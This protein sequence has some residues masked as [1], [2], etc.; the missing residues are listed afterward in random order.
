MVFVI[1]VLAVASS[2]EGIIQFRD[3]IFNFHASINSEEEK[4]KLQKFIDRVNN[5]LQSHASENTKKT[6]ICANLCRKLRNL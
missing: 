1:S 2:A 3:Y 4:C 6:K 5:I